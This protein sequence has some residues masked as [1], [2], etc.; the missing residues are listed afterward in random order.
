[1]GMSPRQTEKKH[2]QHTDDSTNRE[3]DKANRHTDTQ[4]ST[5]TQYRQTDRHSTGAHNADRQ[6]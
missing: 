5:D 1:M 2:R 6:T 3:I 4:Y